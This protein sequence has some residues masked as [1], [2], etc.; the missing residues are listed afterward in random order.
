MFE[1]STTPK[2]GI[3]LGFLQSQK[4]GINLG[5]FV[6]KFGIGSQILSGNPGQWGLQNE[7]FR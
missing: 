5:L 6:S 2:F 4:F 1:K 7:Q 3:N